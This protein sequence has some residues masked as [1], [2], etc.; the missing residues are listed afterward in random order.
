MQNQHLRK[1]PSTCPPRHLHGSD[2]VIHGILSILATSDQITELRLFVP[3]CGGI[4]GWTFASRWMCTHGVPIRSAFA[5]DLDPVACRFYAENHGHQYIQEC[6]TERRLDG[7]IFDGLQCHHSQ[8]AM[9]HAGN[10]AGWNT[11]HSKMLLDMLQTCGSDGCCLKMCHRFGRRLNSRSPFWT[12]WRN[13]D[14][15]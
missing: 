7:S 6:G 14:S 8:L 13:M 2:L 5:I 1:P 3:F 11:G 9:R 10:Q 12:S 4:S 15:L